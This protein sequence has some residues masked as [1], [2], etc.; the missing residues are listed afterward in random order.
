MSGYVLAT[1]SPCFGSD[2]GGS[3]RTLSGIE[4]PWG[5]MPVILSDLDSFP[6]LYGFYKQW[7]SLTRADLEGVRTLGE[8]FRDKPVP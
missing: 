8:F 1:T 7:A 6:A 3:T 2:G 4:S 5:I